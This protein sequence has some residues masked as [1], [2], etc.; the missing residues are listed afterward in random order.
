MRTIFLTFAIIL[1]ILSIC[2]PQCT[3]YKCNNSTDDCKVY[4]EED[5]SYS[6]KKCK[7]ID[8]KC[9]FDET[10]KKGTCQYLPASLP[11]GEKC[12]NDTVCISGKCSGGVC[13]GKKETEDCE[14]TYDC[15]IGLY[16]KDKKCKKVLAVNDTCTDEDECGYDSLCYD[17]KCQKMLSFPSGTQITSS[18]YT[19]LCETNKVIYI[20]GK[21]YCGT[22]TLIG[23]EKECK[24]EQTSCKYTAK[25]GDVTT[26]IEE[27]CKCNAQYKDKKFCPIGSTDKIFQDGIKAFQN[28]L[29]NSAPNHH[30][31][32]KLSPRNYEDRRPIAIADFSPLYDDLPECLYDAFLSTNY[33]KV[34]MFGLFL[35]SLLF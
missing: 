10:T 31:T 30:I 20:E 19:F 22:T 24:G 26:E 18:L 2:T 1:S 12:V 8:Q 15:N 14:N 17:G 7:T 29:T 3:V 32:W 35:L 21:Y 25:Y 27:V 4:S 16:C 34:G 9:N 23:T 6:I 5:G 28:H 33:V 11:A 13:Q